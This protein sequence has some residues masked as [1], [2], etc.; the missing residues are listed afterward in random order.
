MNESHPERNTDVI[1]FVD[2]FAEARGQDAS[3]LDLA[4]RATA[5]LADAY[6]GRRDRVGLISFGG[7]LRWLEPGM[8]M[9][10]LYRIVDALLDTQIILSYY[11]TGIDVIPRRTLPP[12]ALASIP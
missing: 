2:S 5:A 11:W 3:T 1:L 8:G 6:I 10:Q 12:S 7:I 9:V 4:V